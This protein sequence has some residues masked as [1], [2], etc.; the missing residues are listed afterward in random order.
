MRRI[1]G[2]GRAGSM[3]ASSILSELAA[4][5]DRIE[6]VPRE[7]LPEVLSQLEGIRARLQL[8]L[9]SPP[10]P[11]SNADSEPPTD[12]QM[13]DAEEV[14]DRLDVTTRYVYDHADDWPF[15]RPLSPRKLRFSERGLYRWLET[16]Q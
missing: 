1:D 11:S 7:E 9:S 14:A 8:R 10:G 15:T 16:R 13:L 5:P 3:D 6:D 4:D 2:R 12:D